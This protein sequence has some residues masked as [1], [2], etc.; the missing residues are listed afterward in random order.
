[1]KYFAYDYGLTM[2]NRRFDRLFG[3]PPRQPETRLE[4]RHWDIAA[5]VQK[6][7]EEVVLRMAR[8]LHEVT[9]QENLC[10]AGGVALNCVANGRLLREGPFKRLFVQPAAGDAGGAVGVA[11]FIY[12]HVLG[13][14]RKWVWPHAYWGPEYTTEE[15]RQ[16]LD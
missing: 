14:E 9:G 3:G 6:V 7:T 4:Q 5:S 10:M 11:T 8:H 2:T 16:Y 13:H 1:M 12:H 15:I